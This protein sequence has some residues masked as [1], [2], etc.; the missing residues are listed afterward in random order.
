MDELREE[1]ALQLDSNLHNVN[2]SKSYKESIYTKAN[3]ILALI[4]QAG[5]KSPEEL[6]EII[7]SMKEPYPGKWEDRGQ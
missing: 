5:W 3:Q 6:K 2:K 1:I 7:K 4:E